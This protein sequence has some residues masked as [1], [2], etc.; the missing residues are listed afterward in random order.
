MTQCASLN[1]PL[2]LLAADLLLRTQSHRLILKPSEICASQS[3]GALI[4]GYH[5]E[6]KGT[7][8]LKEHTGSV[9]D[10]YW[11]AVFPTPQLDFG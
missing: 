5:V 6:R 9:K 8:R 11:E 2:E 10:G 3:Q 1:S 7:A 4:D